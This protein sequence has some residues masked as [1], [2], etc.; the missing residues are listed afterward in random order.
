MRVAL[1]RIESRRQG[2]YNC[3]VT[4][5]AA[6]AFVV[7]LL[8]ASNTFAQET[9]KVGPKAPAVEINE[10]AIFY[11]APRY[12]RD[13]NRLRLFNPARNSAESRVVDLQTLDQSRLVSP[14]VEA[15][16]SS[17]NGHAP[18]SHVIELPSIRSSSVQ[19]LSMSAD[20][21]SQAAGTPDNSALP[22]K[23]S[24]AVPKV[25]MAET[26]PVDVSKTLSAV[27]ETQPTP[28][29][30]NVEYAKASVPT[31]PTESDL[32]VDSSGQTELAAI[33]PATPPTQ[34]EITSQPSISTDATTVLFANGDATIGESNEAALRVLAGQI[35]A[36]ERTR[37]QLKAYA[38]ARDSSASAARRLSLSRALAVRSFLIES[39][40]NSTRIDV[41][42][43]GAKSE[44]GPEDRVDLVI[45]N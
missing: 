17:N 7:S 8:T 20:D 44:S 23:D 14:P 36:E 24:V 18:S 33:T 28:A 45:V 43:L 30:S 13:N 4:S 34:T 40:V 22:Q 6:A 15:A 19:S 1:R 26:K 11:S 10:D 42:A 12:I 2:L 25:D 37:L 16:T 35:N 38:G 31:P 3:N 39:G 32:S 29:A 5:F 9:T 27:R 21:T 41:R